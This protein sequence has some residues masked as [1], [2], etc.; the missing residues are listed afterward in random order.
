M[1]FAQLGLSDEAL[2]AI[3]DAGYTEP[4]P[5]QDRAIP[6][7]LQGRDLFGVAQT[8][9]GKTASF[10]LPMID[11]LAAGHAKARIPR[12]LIVEPTRE[13]AAQVADNF[14]TYG[15]YH[16]L[17]TAL[18]IGGVRMDEQNRKVDRGV[19]VLIATPGRLLD[20]AENGR[21]MLSGIKILVIDEADRL[22]DMGFM[23]DVEKIVAQLSPMRQTLFFSA[24][25]PPEIRRLAGKFLQNPKEVAVSP[26]A[27]PAEMV[28]QSIVLVGAS[29]K[30]E[31]LRSLLRAE[32]VSQAL[33][34]CNRKRDIGVLTRSLKR[35]GFEAAEL[36][37]DMAQP[38]RTATLAKFKRDEVGLLVASDV[39][40]RGL[41]IQGLP[42]VFCFD[43]PTHAEDYIHRI[44]RT[45]RAGLAG[46]S[47]MLATPM[48][49]KYV[50]AIKSMLGKDI[51]PMSV[52]G[53]AAIEKAGAE[54]ESE[55]SR[56]RRVSRRRGGKETAT[57]RAKS[58]TSGDKTERRAKSEPRRDRKE[59]GERTQRAAKPAEKPVVKAAEKPATKPPR[60]NKVT[61]TPKSRRGRSAERDDGAN[62]NA[63]GLGD[64]VPAFLQRPPAKR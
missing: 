1:T 8:G 4:T 53:L 46:R 40:A 7:I 52:D 2:R 24:T 54:P 59:A 25:M 33:I 38:A 27:S 44:G 42:H 22:L 36:H 50:A 35:H 13:L 10:T 14:A 49:S 48:E 30:R 28:S 63:L 23:P 57:P 5:I 56:T 31:A 3:Q 19:D 29:D 62:A 60:K 61:R 9:T 51:P 45:G 43:V 20:H 11:I 21:L 41:D 34:F 18:L 15:K 58:E 47:I 26:P 64:H 17:S 12:S 32:N 55:R 16:K 37:G 39:A 6:L